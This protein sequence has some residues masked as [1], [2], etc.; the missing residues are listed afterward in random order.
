MFLII[1]NQQ[2]ITPSLSHRPVAIIH[3]SIAEEDINDVSYIV[4]LN[5]MVNVK[6]TPFDKKM[7]KNE[8]NFFSPY[9]E[10][11]ANLIYGDEN[12][13]ILNVSST[14]HCTFM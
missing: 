11:I 8:G 12:N 2:L 6:S 7:L 14:H 9:E 3:N 13:C 10:E 4:Q 5:I 1:T